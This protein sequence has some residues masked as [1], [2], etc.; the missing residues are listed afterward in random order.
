MQLKRIELCVNIPGPAS[1]DEPL[2]QIEIFALGR[3]SPSIL[4][5]VQ[6]G[7]VKRIIDYTGNYFLSF[8][9]QNRENI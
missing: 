9:D 2:A 1:G 4:E 5:A 7:S 3:L 8:P 6:S